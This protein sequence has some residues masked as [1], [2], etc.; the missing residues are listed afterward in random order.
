ME[1]IENTQN[2]PK[3]KRPGT[4]DVINSKKMHNDI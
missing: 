1:N 4:D 3:E 2:Q